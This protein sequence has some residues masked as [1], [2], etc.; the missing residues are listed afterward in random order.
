[1][2]IFNGD[3]FYGV[4][5]WGFVD[6]FTKIDAKVYVFFLD[7]FTSNGISDIQ[8]RLFFDMR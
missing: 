8:I 5:L 2:I 7:S 1:M 4:N 6:R 3:H